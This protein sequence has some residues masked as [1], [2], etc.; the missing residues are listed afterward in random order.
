M[1]FRSEGTVSKNVDQ[2][3]EAFADIGST[4]TPAGFTT[5]TGGFARALALTAEMM[6]HPTLDDAGIERRKALQAA[7]ARRL[8]QIPSA[9]PRHLFYAALY[10]AD[11][12]YVRSLVPT[13]SSVA[14]I[15]RDDV[16]RFYEENFRPQTTT[17]VVA[18]DVS[19][20][21]ATAAVTRAF[22]GWQ[23][24]P[25]PNRTATARTRPSPSPTTIYLHDV[26]GPQAYVYVG[27]LGPARTSPDFYAV[28]TMGVISGTRMQRTL[29]DRRSIMY[30]G[31]SGVI[32]RRA[33]QPSPLVGST[34]V[35]AAKV[36]SALV[37]WLSLLRGLSGD[38]PVTPQ[39]LE[40]ARRSRVGA[41]AARIDGPGDAGVRSLETRSGA[42]PDSDGAD[43]AEPEP[44]DYLPP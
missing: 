5:T 44:N 37:E 18:G 33:P 32:W 4:A 10:G 39:E 23:R 30:S 38:Q 34:A 6:M 3:A 28:E 31:N 15:T 27:G 43:A 12:P 25:A 8:S 14:A 16:A 26:P 13:E 2:L 19:D 11:D 9:V 29:R 21:A 1:L 22:G 7:N 36:D 41:L 35:N 20:A 40:A 17:I 42:Q 24:G